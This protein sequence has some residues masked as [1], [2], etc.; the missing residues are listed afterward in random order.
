MTSLSSWPNS[1][2]RLSF[3]LLLRRTS[4]GD[5]TKSPT[6][7]TIWDKNRTGGYSMIEPTC[8]DCEHRFEDLF[9]SRPQFLNRMGIA[10]VA[11]SITSLLGMVLLPVPGVLAAN[12]S[13]ELVRKQP[14]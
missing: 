7:P 3:L 6:D 2:P 13:S 11:L 1:L 12:S 14:H 4:K 5:V 8:Q 10:F 9:L